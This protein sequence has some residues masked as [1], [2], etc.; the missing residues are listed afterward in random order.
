MGLRRVSN[1]SMSVLLVSVEDVLRLIYSV[2]QKKLRRMTKFYYEMNMICMMLIVDLVDFNGH[3]GWDIDEFDCGHG[4]YDVGQRNL[5][6][7]MLLL[8]HLEK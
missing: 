5:E 6:G 7:R 4:G 1:K 2:R 8:F 3:V